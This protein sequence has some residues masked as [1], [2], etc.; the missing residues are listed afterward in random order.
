V[1]HV[2]VILT[3]LVQVVRL[4]ATLIERVNRHRVITSAVTHGVV[5][6]ISDQALVSVHLR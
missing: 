6:L 1:K 5:E 2:S 4:L 3:L